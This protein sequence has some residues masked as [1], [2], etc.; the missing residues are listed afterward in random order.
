[1]KRIC[2]DAWCGRR[3]TGSLPVRPADFLIRCQECSPIADNINRT[4]ERLGV[5]EAVRAGNQN[6]VGKASEFRFFY[7]KAKIALRMTMEELKFRQSCQQSE[8]ESCPRQ[9]DNPEDALD[10]AEVTSG[11]QRK[12]G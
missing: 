12:I 6:P 7:L 11:Q 3:N 9:Y 4:L 10:Q 2:R 5:I 1:M 8:V